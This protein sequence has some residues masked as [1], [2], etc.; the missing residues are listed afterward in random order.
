MKQMKNIWNIYKLDLK[1]IV[2]NFVVAILIGGL[3]ILPSL[4]AWLNIKASW[5]PYAQT[6]QI[7][8][9]VVN[10]DVGAVIRDKQVNVGDELVETLK[11]NTD[12]NWNF[13]NRQTAIDEVEYGNYYAVIVVPSNFS[14]TLGTVITDQPTKAE[15]EYYVNEKINAVAPKIT[16][17]G[18]S[19]IVEQIS[20]QFISTVNGIIFE[21]FNDIGIELEAN[22][23]DIQQFEEYIFTIEKELPSIHQLLT[24]TKDDA[25]KA[26]EIMNKA[27]KLMPEAKEMVSSGI[28]TVD[29]IVALLDEAEQ[30]LHNLAPKIN[31]ELE[32]IQSTFANLQQKLETLDQLS[33]DEQIQKINDLN[34]QLNDSIQYLDEMENTLKQIQ[35]SMEVENNDM[36][37]VIEEIEALKGLFTT[38]QTELTTI[39]EYLINNEE[40]INENLEH[41]KGSITTENLD[42]FVKTYKEKIEPAVL[43]EVAKGKKKIQQTKNML[44]EVSG[45]IPEIE[46]LLESTSTH[47]HEGQGM[48]DSVLNQFPYVHDKVKEVAN[49]IRRI[50]SDADVH[51]IIQLLQNDPEKE[52]G[53]FAEPVVLNKNEIFPIPNYGTGMTPFYTVLALWVGALLL[54][55]LL[56]TDV[57]DI[58]NLHSREVYIGR[59]LTF[60]TIGLLQTFIVTSGDILLVGVSVSSPIWFILFGLFIS[61]IFMTI[62]YTVVSVFGDVGKA[63]AIVLLVLQISSSGGTYPVVLLPGFFQAINPFLPFTYA[64]DLMREAVGGIIW[65][66][67]L[68]DIL[69]LLLFGCIFITGGIFLKGPINKQMNKL[70]KSKDSRLFH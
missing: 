56:S 7:P 33:V 49:E 40:S 62:V 29:S 39:S 3:V 48:L 12:F 57:S 70:M 17:K 36:Q 25:N 9:G 63:I 47:L 42:T 21:M 35:E 11:E 16:D 65:G 8:I 69:I 34:A 24:E 66:R 53:F 22:L 14:E 30:S 60:M 59:L 61:L 37:Y 38:M 45:T 31:E 4:Y 43:N 15:I 41:V 50:Q 54:I 51:D 27:N 2:T 19:V 5:D 18:A 28:S 23:P 44:N 68:K 46:R 32:T 20:S 6:D 55:S 64:V 26:D 1:N 52:R 10:E 67:A 13:V 58:S